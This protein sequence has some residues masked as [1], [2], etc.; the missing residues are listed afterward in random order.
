MLG[1][2]EVTEL[3]VDLLFCDGR[4][5]DVGCGGGDIR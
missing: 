2:A 3:I 5:L 4:V 1:D